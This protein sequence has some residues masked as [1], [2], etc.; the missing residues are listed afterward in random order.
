MS[1]AIAF[2]VSDRLI[3]AISEENNPDIGFTTQDVAPDY[4][5]I[6]IENDAE[7][8]HCIAAPQ[9]YLCFDN[10]TVQSEPC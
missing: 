10:V 5:V 7:Y 4:E 1:F 2:Q 3:V 8:A 9:T 6:V